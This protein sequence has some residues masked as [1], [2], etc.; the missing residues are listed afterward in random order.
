[1]DYVG[2]CVVETEIMTVVG[3]LP[4]RPLRRNGWGKLTKRSDGACGAREAK[5]KVRHDQLL[6]ANF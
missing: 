5:D 4:D 6:R 2:V 1:M 3:S